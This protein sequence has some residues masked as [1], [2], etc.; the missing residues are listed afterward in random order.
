MIVM[1]SQAPACAVHSYPLAHNDEIIRFSLSRSFSAGGCCEWSKGWLSPDKRSVH[2]NNVPGAI[3]PELRCQ[4]AWLCHPV[5]AKYSTRPR[6]SRYISCCHGTTIEGL[7]LCIISPVTN[8]CV[9]AGQ[10]DRGVHPWCVLYSPWRPG[11]KTRCPTL[12]PNWQD[13]FGTCAPTKPR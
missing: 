13:F 4:E 10:R 9:S 8:V 2:A 3:V 11:L 12:D 5:S 7:D 6:H 1:A